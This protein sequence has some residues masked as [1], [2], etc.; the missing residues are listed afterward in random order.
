MW[1]RV[2]RMGG[3]VVLCAASV[4]QVLAAEAWP[5][6][7]VTIVVPFVAGGS[8][9]V[10]ARML[11]GKLRAEFGQSFVVENRGG[12]GGNIGAEYAAKAGPDGYTLFL[13][14]STNV[15]NMSLYRNLPFDMIRDFVPVSQVAFIPNILVVHNAVPVSNL[16]EFLKYIQTTRNKV[17]YGS[18]GTGSSLHLAAA[19]FDKL[20]KGR[21]THVP[22][23]GSAPA[24]IDLLGGHIQA[25]FPP[26]V[27]AL[28]HIKSGKLKALGVTTKNRSALLAEVPAI[29]EVLSGYEVALWNGI[30][31]PARTPPEIVNRLNESIVKILRQADTK[32]LLAEQ[33]SEPVGSSITQFKEF[34]G[35]ELLKWRSLVEVSGARVE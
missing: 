22:Y 21:M 13:A 20:A 25:A 14:T 1:K 10:T 16:A 31:A 24:I 35:R 26:L 33:G 2:V 7:P 4:V 6:K 3:L 34:V 5:S 9:D 30:F 19:L 23:K 18:A 32:K 8:T 29:G 17:D 11:A 12:A 15:T 28:P 27:D